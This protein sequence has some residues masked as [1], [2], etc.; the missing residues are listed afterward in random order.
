M[1]TEQSNRAG[2]L[3]VEDDRSLA[4]LYAEW[5]K[6]SYDVETAYDGTEALE[7]LDETVDVVL[8]DR[9]MPGFSGGEVLEAIRDADIDPRVVM[10][11][12][13]TPDLD[14][15]Q[16]GFDGYL[17]KPVDA[18]T[19]HETLDRMLTRAEYDEKL[20]ELFSLIERQDT[21]EA[22]KK[23]EVLE[24]SEEYRSLTDRLT[25]VQ[26]DVESML[27]DLPEK[28]FQVAVERL[29]RTAAE[30]TSE[31]RYESLTEDV[32]DSSSEA[33]VVVD[34]DGSVVWANEATETLLGFNRGDLRGRGYASAAADRLEDV[35][36]GEESLA[37]LIQTGLES[38][39][40]ELDA[41]VH[42]PA[43]EGRAER[44]LEYRSAPV[45][46]GLYAGGRIEHYHDI[47]GRYR[48][49]QYLQALHR[50][51]R[52]LMAA[53]TADLVAERAVIT[54][55][56]DLDFPYAALFTRKTGTGDLVPAADE[57]TDH[58][59]G[60]SL[61]T[62]SGGP[63]PVWTAF[64]D[65]TGP[66]EAETHRDENGSGGWLDDDFDDWM[67]CPLGQ[68]GVFLV[69]TTEGTLSAGD[70]NLAQ[71]WAA[72][73]QQ[74]L[75]QIARTQNLKDR[76]REL[77]QQ[78]ERLSRLDRINRLIRSIS[79]AVVSA[80]TRREIE[81]AVC[82]R[83]LRIDP[84]TGAWIADVD[85]A[86]DG[87]VCRAFSGDLEDYLSDV[88]RATA[89]TGETRSIEATPA[90]PAKRA[91]ETR[92]SVS[93]TDLVA[94]DSGVWWRDRGL[95]RGTNTIV[96]IPVVHESTRFGAIE[97]HIDRPRGMSDEEIEAFG[98][99]GVTIAH[100][101]DAI[102]QRDALLSGGGTD[103]TFQV[104]SES[105]LSRFVTE[106]DAPL[107]VTDVSRQDDGTCA[108]FLTLDID[109][110]ED[111]DRIEKQVK[112]RTGASVLRTDTAGMTCVL[113]LGAG[114]PIQQMVRH[115]V[116]LQEV[117]IRP[118]SEML[119]V[120]VRLSYETEVREY[121]EAITNAIDDV[122]LISKRHRS[123][124]VSSTVA[125]TVHGRL[126]DRQ[127]ETLRMAF[128]AGYFDQPRSTDAGTVAEELGIAQSTLSQHLR[129]AERKLIE[130]LFS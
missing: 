99:L 127:R 105:T 44:W 31:R 123:A 108:V 82:R 61:P 86:T 74:A 118:D 84:V 15:V 36:A 34:A 64:A 98:E 67:L 78:N 18:T 73:T 9:K 66:L 51:T 28:D 69:A 54:A 71:T 30:R 114:S 50:A 111:R 37:S 20:Q 91:Y 8:L 110:S 22:V 129:T 122:E 10:V 107:T 103:L 125:T 87:L 16:M 121:V 93:V 83:L 75:E 109:T 106:V 79:P 65:R 40:A 11:S 102:R 72:S 2:V 12:A 42:V 76:D 70:R 48:R 97:V 126:T 39:G 21:L 128:H 124:P 55:T 17:E 53:E 5:L 68:Q 62:I 14:V 3:V 77:E 85:L 100:G 57:T 92:S 101:I 33:T 49:E 90:V 27:T 115:G 23:S 112:N 130:T 19:L 59:T 116:A 35:D 80:D 29:Q 60:P 4:D 7:R 81:T 120:R 89:E 119:S 26:T 24:A 58:T 96:A 56:T 38:Q 47:T 6:G 88:P 94:I 45:E 113:T 43:E 117:A 32:L 1:M 95:R 104:N 25:Q 13:V 63:D 52:D 41:T 46:T